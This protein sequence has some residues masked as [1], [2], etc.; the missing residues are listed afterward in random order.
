VQQS[1]DLE[2]YFEEVKLSLA[3]INLT[4]PKNHLPPAEREALKALCSKCSL[5][6]SSKKTWL[7]LAF[8]NPI[9]SV[10][11]SDEK[12]TLPCVWSIASHTAAITAAKRCRAIFHSFHNLKRKGNSGCSYL[13]KIYKSQRQFSIYLLKPTSFQRMWMEA[14]ATE[15]TVSWTNEN[16]NKTRETEEIICN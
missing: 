2:S 8:F 1:V 13:K 15:F 14:R 7:H 10:W 16:V 4:K 11:I 6:S 9:L 5:W 12:N 3:E